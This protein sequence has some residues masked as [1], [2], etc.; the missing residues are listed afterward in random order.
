[1]KKFVLLATGGA[2][3]YVLGAKAGRPAYD[4]IVRGWNRLSRSVGLSEVGRSVGK[5]AGDLRDAAKDRAASQV[6]DLMYRATDAVAPA[7]HEE[8]AAK[9]GGTGTHV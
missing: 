2:I 5:S 7:N 9:N 4:Q 6:E 1:M 3:G 8:A